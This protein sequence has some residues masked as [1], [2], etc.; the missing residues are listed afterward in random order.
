MSGGG[1]LFAI[2]GQASPP[3]L[4]ASWRLWSTSLLQAPWFCWQLRA[5]MRAGD[6]AAVRS[7]RSSLWKLC[8]IG[9]VL[10]AHFGCWV[11]AIDHTSLAHSLLFVSAHP[12]ILILAAWV[13][14]AGW[15]CCFRGAAAAVPEADGVVPQAAPGA[16]GPD[17][18]RR[19]SALESAG[20]A[21]GCV[22]AALMVALVDT[23][24]SP[25]TVAG[26]A[27][28]LGG[29]AAMA[30]YLTAGRHFRSRVRLPLFLYAFPV[31]LSAAMVATAAS[32]AAEGPSHGVA[33][34]GPPSVG[35]F[36]WLRDGRLAAVVVALGMVSGILGH[37]L[38]NLALARLSPLVVSVGLLLEPLAGSVIG[39]AA[40]VQE[41]PQPWTFGGGAILLIG[42]GLVTIGG[43]RAAP[44]PALDQAERTPHVRL[45]SDGSTQ[46]E[47]ELAGPS[48]E[49]PA[50]AES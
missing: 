7:F 14:W 15:F 29:A 23:S 1:T 2:I 40:G 35:V 26:D 45:K 39:Y 46:P 30:V 42:A 5:L 11:W 18:P 32:L 21:I 6:A 28:A 50:D 3:L 48:A 4:K 31:T 41:V 8:V 27:V 10:A 9:V 13:V 20:T 16:T 12:V 37:T 47:V 19:P 25:V 38:A 44:P 36:G 49:A 43:D 22:G 24:S 17:G 34:G 33:F